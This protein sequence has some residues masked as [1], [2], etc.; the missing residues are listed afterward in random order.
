MAARHKKPGI[1]KT[2]WINLLGNMNVYKKKCTD[3]K[4]MY[5]DLLL[6]LDKRIAKIIWVNLQRNMNICTKFH[7]SI[8]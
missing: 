2:V 6:V 4:T 5:F 7:E 1:T 8:R 3:Q